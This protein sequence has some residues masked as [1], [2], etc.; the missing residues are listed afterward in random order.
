MRTYSPFH[1]KKNEFLSINDV[2]YAE[3]NQLSLLDEGYQLEFK[4]NFNDSV[5][6]KIP[7]I[8]TSFANSSGGWIIIGIDDKSKS[9]V[10]IK[11]ERNDFGQIVSQLLK[12]CVTPIPQYEVRFLECPDV[13]TSGILL[14]YVY[15]GNFA[16]YISDGTIYIRNGSSKEPVQRA[17]RATIELLLDKSNQHKKTMEMFFKRDIHFPYN[18]LLHKTREYSLCNVYLKNLADINVFKTYQDKENIKKHLIQDKDSIFH[19][20]QFNLNSILFRHKTITPF[21]NGITMLY[22]LYGDMSTKI[23]VPLTTMSD[24][25]NEY[26]INKICECIS[27]KIRES[28]KYKIIDG[29]LALDYIWASIKKHVDLLKKYDISI[30]DLVLQMECEDI[31]N[32]ILYF[33]CPLYFEYIKKNGLCF[34]QKQS[35]KTK[36]IY[37]KDCEGLTYEQLDQA[38]AFDLFAHMFGFHPVRMFEIHREAQKLKYPDLFEEDC[39]L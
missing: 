4:L 19:S 31:E 26:A 9:I 24:S 11:R 17:D 29:V 32:T 25:D 15:E 36:I 5:K 30:S 10:P 33:D 22:E 3:L 34:S 12:G 27:A 37:L 8:M 20:A 21:D 1:N 18:N 23:Y 16:P 35:E 14:I 28:A 7:A 38:I 6:K 39:L 13:K 2:T